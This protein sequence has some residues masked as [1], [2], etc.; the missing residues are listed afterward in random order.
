MGGKDARAA[1]KAKGTRG[2]AEGP[3]EA[4][5]R[6]Q[7]SVKYK[8]PADFI[9]DEMRWD[10]W[11]RLEQA[12]AGRDRHT[13]APRQMSSNEGAGQVSKPWEQLT[14]AGTKMIPKADN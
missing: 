6:S 9:E 11:P 12:G 2:K 8:G 3:G 10:P 5:L 1:C 13:P 7:L 4:S 14:Q